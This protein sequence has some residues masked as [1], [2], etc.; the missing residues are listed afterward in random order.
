MFFFLFLLWSQTSPLSPV[1]FLCLQRANCQGTG[2]EACKVAKSTYPPKPNSWRSLRGSARP[3]TSSIKN[4]SSSTKSTKSTSTTISRTTSACS[5]ASTAILLVPPA[6]VITALYR[7]SSCH[8]FEKNGAGTT[9]TRSVCF[10]SV[11]QNMRKFHENSNGYLAIHCAGRVKVRFK[12]WFW[13]V[14]DKRHHR[15]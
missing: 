2:P 3:G 4:T 7:T 5:S 15:R 9:A 8:H 12:A 10:R 14:W 6:G 13:D 1:D 11:C